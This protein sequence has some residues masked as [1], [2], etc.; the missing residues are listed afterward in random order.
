MRIP[1][2]ILR[3]RSS[4]KIAVGEQPGEYQS[5]VKPGKNVRLISFFERTGVK[6]RTQESCGDFSG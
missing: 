4:I 6:R 2:E 1:E 5:I 3:F